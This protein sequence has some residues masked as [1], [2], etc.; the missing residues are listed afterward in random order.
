MDLEAAESRLGGGVWVGVENSGELKSGAPPTGM[1]GRL[2]L[3]IIIP[4]AVTEDFK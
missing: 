2:V 1:L 4:S 3:V